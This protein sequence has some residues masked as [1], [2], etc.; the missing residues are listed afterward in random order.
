MKFFAFLKEE[1]HPE[2]GEKI[3][4]KEEFSKLIEANEIVQKAIDDAAIYKEKVKKECEVLKEEAKK[5]GFDQGLKSLN[6]HILKLDKTSKELAKKY[7]GKVL[8]IALKAAKKIVSAEL[9]M[10][11]EAIVN[12]VRGALKPISQH[13]KVKIFVNK[14]DLE[15]IEKEKEKIKEILQIADT[16]TIEERDDIEPGGC[17][18]ETEKG[19]INAQLENQFR[20]I[21]AAF[22]SFEK[23]KK[24]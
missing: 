20:A 3:I 13:I 17:I 24:L 14:E 10:N 6:E 4:P 18:I 22:K 12:I 15:I 23:T 2:P 5:E 19:I 11:P 7:E 9:K 16:F 1:I 8:P 21:E